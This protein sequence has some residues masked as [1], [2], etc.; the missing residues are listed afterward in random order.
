MQ[1]RARKE[2][3][4]IFF[5]EVMT[6]I[7]RLRANPGSVS[8]SAA[9]RAQIR[10][11]LAIA[12]DAAARAEYTREDVLFAK[13]A[14]VAFLDES[15]LNSANPALIEWVR[16][17]LQEEMFGVHVAG[18]IFFRNL[19]KVLERA[20]SPDTADLLEVF[21]LCLELGFRGR[22]V[23]S[24]SGETR[25]YIQRAIEKIRRIRGTAPPPAP[26]PDIAPVKHDPWQKRL[27]VTA[28]ALGILAIVLFAAYKLMLM[29]GSSTAA[30][31][32]EGI[33]L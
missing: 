22:F 4:A 9:F 8:D 21:V 25:A 23:S 17:P 29:S 33:S 16:Q 28:G 32:A 13:F 11:A 30:K 5:Q 15:V 18:E 19:D 3:L 2:N 20:D 6:A 26:A 7:V 14:T 31:L 24:G 27:L 12:E 1:P 10:N